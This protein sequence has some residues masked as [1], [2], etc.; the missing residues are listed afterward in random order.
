MDINATLQ[1]WINVLT[2]PSEATFVEEQHKPQANF[3]TAIIWMVITGVVAGIMGWLSFTLFF[4]SGNGFLTMLDQMNLPREVDQQMRQMLSGGMMG[5]MAGGSAFSSII[6]TPIFFLIGASLFYLIGRLFGG[7]GDLGRYAYLLA[8]F[9]APIGIIGAILGLIPV[10]GSCLSLILSIYG[11]VLTYF[12][13]KVE[14]NLTSGRAIAV[15]LT[16]VI[17]F[18]VLIFCLVVSMFGLISSMQNQ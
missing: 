14:L 4:G 2:H 17:V 7:S 15:I 6:M 9:Q 10:A 1:T 5:M 16:P 13:T 3:T 11:L 12:A 18:F 8:S